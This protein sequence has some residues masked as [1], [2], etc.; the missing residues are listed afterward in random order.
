MI[1]CFLFCRLGSL[2]KDHGKDGPKKEKEKEKEKEKSDKE[3]LERLN[4]ET[5]DSHGKS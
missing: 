5:T 2:S 4:I 1:S 3:D